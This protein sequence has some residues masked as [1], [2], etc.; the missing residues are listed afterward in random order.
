MK[1]YVELK[2][3]KAH[4]IKSNMAHAILKTNV[5]AKAHVERPELKY[6]DYWGFK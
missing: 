4:V 5:N 2:R 3:I 6:K 1:S